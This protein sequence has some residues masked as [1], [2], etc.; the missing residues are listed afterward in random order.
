M[1]TGLAE[2]HDEAKRGGLRRNALISAL[3]WN[4]PQ[5]ESLVEF[6]LEDSDPVIVATPRVL[7][8]GGKIHQGPR[9]S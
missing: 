1:K 2:L 9:F 4:H 5:L 7:V 8:A 3:A 6:C